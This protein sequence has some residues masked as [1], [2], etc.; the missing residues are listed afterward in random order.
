[1]EITVTKPINPRYPWIKHSEEITQFLIGL[2]ELKNLLQVENM[3]FLVNLNQVIPEFLGLCRVWRSV[4]TGVP[5]GVQIDICLAKTCPNRL[6]F[7]K[8]LIH[9]LWH[10]KQNL[11]GYLDSTF[12]NAGGYYW[13]NKFYAWN[14]QNYYKLNKAPWEKEA[15]LAEKVF[16]KDVQDFYEKLLVKNSKLVPDQVSSQA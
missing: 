4:R 13:Y 3:P 12:F 14:N 5:T 7:F 11:T 15:K 8:T 10:A 9:E 16:L 6:E 2:F 1:M